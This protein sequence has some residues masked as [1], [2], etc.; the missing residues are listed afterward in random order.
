MR[1]FWRA[2]GY[3]GEGRRWL[4]RALSEEG[5]TSAAARAKALDGVGWLASEQHDI[6]RVQAAGEEGL[7]LSEEAEIGGVILANFKN[8]L[9][10]AAWLRGDYER[11]AGCSK[12]AW[13]FIGKLGTPGASRGPSA[14]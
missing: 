14:A 5:R 9:G 8:L 3:Y 4:E 12:K 7:E 11:A 2:R 10:E 1:W 13:C 6:D